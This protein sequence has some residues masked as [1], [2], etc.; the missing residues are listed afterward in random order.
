LIGLL[1]L[2]GCA[3]PTPYVPA[4]RP[5]GEGFGE[6]RIEANRF[7]VQFKGNSV[8]P[9][10]TVDTYLLNRAAELTVRTGYDYFVVA[11]LKTDRDTSYRSDE[12]FGFGGYGGYGG[13]R[14]GGWGGAGIGTT[15]S[16]PINEFIT[17][18][19]VLMFNGR[20]PAGDPHAYDARDVLN[21]IGP[22]VIRLAP[23]GT[24]PAR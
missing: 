24:Q 23:E 21:R 16:Q 13:W 20:K 15:Y 5:D 2:A 17:V 9:R 12:P 18:A 3:Y 19:D 7:R 1:V 4:A 11:N 22:T 8:T 6:Q 14:R 10:E